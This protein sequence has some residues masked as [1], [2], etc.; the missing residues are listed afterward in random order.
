MKTA[1]ASPM[2]RHA[3]ELTERELQAILAA[4]DIARDQTTNAG[5]HWWHST[6]YVNR[7]YLNLRSHGIEAQA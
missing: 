3:I 7:L 4:M 1:V 6:A 5:W 2:T